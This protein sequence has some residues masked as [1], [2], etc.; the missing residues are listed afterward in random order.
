MGYPTQE[1]L[2]NYDDY[3]IY[4]NERKS[5]FYLKA[6]IP[7]TNNTI[8]RVIDGNINE[9]GFIKDR[10]NELSTKILGNNSRRIVYLEDQGTFHYIFELVTPEKQKYIIKTS[11]GDFPYRAYDFFIDKWAMEELSRYDIPHVNIIDVD[12]TRSKYPF[13][14]MIMEKAKGKTLFEIRRTEKDYSNCLID[15]GKTLA[16]IHSIAVESY[17]LLDIDHLLKLHKGKGL[18]SN[19]T[20][21]VYK[22]L[23]CDLRSCFDNGLI[24]ETAKKSIQTVF[25]KAKEYIEVPKSSLLH[26]DLSNK[27]IFIF[28]KA[29]SAIIDWEDC[30][31][32]DSI[33]DIA[34]WGTFVGNHNKVK[35]IIDGYKNFQ[36]LNEDFEIRYWIYYL[37][38]ILAKTIHR[39]RFGYS[40]TDKILPSERINLPLQ[41]I[42]KII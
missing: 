33:F 1:N 18:Q 41:E 11:R 19:W 42:E 32:G 3:N 5:V 27:N 24:D 17:G 30:L 15:F 22:N 20:D 35:L 31:C 9:I 8:L 7:V 13:D 34:C 12:V 37:R 26:G 39:L 25:L 38:I 29:V 36:K 6:D 40:K 2:M 14:Y 4:L 28:D 21:F 10:L 16:K 23:E